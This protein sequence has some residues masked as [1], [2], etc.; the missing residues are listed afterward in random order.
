MPNDYDN[1]G[2]VALWPS[3][4][5]NP[6]A[7]QAKGTVVAHRDIKEGETVD[8]ALWRREPEHDRQPVMQGRI[9]DRQ[10]QSGPAQQSQQQ[11]G[12]DDDD[13]PPF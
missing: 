6:N 4:S 1:R 7:P 9:S 8:I 2:R 10:Q 13:I 3:R 5:E 12:D 11:G